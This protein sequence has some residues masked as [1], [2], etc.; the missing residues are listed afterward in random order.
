L[1]ALRVALLAH[2]N[3]GN[4]PHRRIT[5][6]S[7]GPSVQTLR[8]YASYTGFSALRTI[9]FARRAT[10]GSGHAPRANCVNAV[11]VAH[12][13]PRISCNRGPRRALR[14]I[15]E[16]VT[17]QKDANGVTDCQRGRG[18]YCGCG[19]VYPQ[20]QGGC[21]VIWFADPGPVHPAYI[22]DNSA[23]ACP[24]LKPAGVIVA[25]WRA[26]CK[27]LHVLKQ[28]SQLPEYNALIDQIKQPLRRYVV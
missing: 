13:K 1:R 17:V 2:S 27:K 9:A 6:A 8:A 20:R 22:Q 24:T 28:A 19:A 16:Q 11:P 15:A 26:G 14:R 3:K 25:S 18:S 5:A 10:T 21:R 23:A 4:K 12:T 7:W